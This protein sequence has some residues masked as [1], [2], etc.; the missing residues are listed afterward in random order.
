MT[1]S[2]LAKVFLSLIASCTYFFLPAENAHAVPS[3]ARQTGF[4]C[5][6]CHTVFPELTPLGRDFKLNGYT[7]SQTTDKK[8]EPVP[9]IS[10]MLQLD[11]TEQKGLKNRVNPYDDSPNGKF[12]LPSQASIFY[13][14]R[15]YDRLGAF[16]QLTYAGVDNSLA[17]DNVDIRFA[18]TLTIRG[19]NLVYGVT[20]NNNPTVQD[21]WNTIPVWGFPFVSSPVAVTPAAI[22]VVD[23]LLAQQVGGIGLYGF[24]NNW[25]YAE[26]S[27]YR[28][29]QKGITRPLGAG[30]TTETVVD[31][32]VP[33]WRV[34]LQH[35]FGDHYFSLGTY[36]LVAKIFPE[37]GT[38]GPSDRFTDIALDG[39]YQFITAKHL[40][41]LRTTWI[42]EKQ[43]RDASFAL[44]LSNQE[45][46]LKTFRINASYNYVSPWGTLGGT[47]GYFTT[48]GDQ[49]AS[50]FSPAPITGSATGKPDSRGYI[51]EANYLPWEKVKITAQY[52]IF[53]KFNG[54]S[55]NYDGSGRNASDNNFF[56]L[57]IWIAF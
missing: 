49:D 24:W 13:A 23:G 3:F 45:D 54:D 55:S 48:T 18:N 5:N 52:T 29:N 21:V 9:P 14:G 26:A 12:T 50:L 28:T 32:A 11:Y 20:V 51:L 6:V 43:E 33:Y 46:V 15:I 1:W 27:V 16:A 44:G 35:Q 19:T 7:Q 37:G 30:T 36:G 31:G 53:D 34:A 39:Q 38:S 56:Y 42:H 25:I 8:Y 4:S 47:F 57:N 22:T 40:I 2:K 17:L 41:S 10:A